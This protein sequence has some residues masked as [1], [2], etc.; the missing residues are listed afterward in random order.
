MKDFLIPIEQIEIL[1]Q[2]DNYM[3]ERETI[4][5][6]WF[7]GLLVNLSER[8]IHN[9][10]QIQQLIEEVNIIKNIRHPNIEMHLGVSFKKEVKTFQVPGDILPQQ[11]VSYKFYMVTK[12]LE[13]QELK[14]DFQQSPLRSNST[15]TLEQYMH[16]IR[17]SILTD[18]DN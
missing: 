10:F 8:Q 7:K 17:Q 13:S 14:H 12:N 4:T 18:K 15:S 3:Q 16:D 2:D 5:G 1:P 9:Q 6:K 11:E